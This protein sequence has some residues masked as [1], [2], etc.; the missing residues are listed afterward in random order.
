M[1][2]RKRMSIRLRDVWCDVVVL[3]YVFRAEL[4]G[5]E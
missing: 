5:L 1:I 2:V 3:V 4:R